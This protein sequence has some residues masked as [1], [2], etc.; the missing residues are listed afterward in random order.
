MTVKRSR[1]SS[2]VKRLELILVT[3]LASALVCALLASV[4]QEMVTRKA[5]LEGQSSAWLRAL[6]VQC[7]SALVF[8]DSAAASDILKAAGSFPGLQAILLL[9]AD[10]TVLA[11]QADIGQAPIQLEDLGSKRS[12]FDGALHISTHVFAIN[13]LVGTVHARIDLAPL[14]Q[15]LLKFALS[16]TAVLAVSG[17]VAAL[18]ARRFLRRAIMPMVDLKHAMENVTAGQNY[19]IRAVINAR[20]EVGELSGCFNAMLDQI[21]ER[22]RLLAINHANLM[23]LKDQAEQAS[24]TK[25]DFLALMSHELRTPMAGVIGMLGLALRSNMPAALRDQ[26]Q[27]TKKNAVSLLDIVNDLLDLSKIEAGKLTLER[28]DFAMAPLLDDALL[29]LHER[30]QQKSVGFVVQVDPDVPPFLLGD[31]TRLRQVLINLVGNAIKFTEKGHVRVRV[32]RVPEAGMDAKAAYQVIRFSVSD[33]GIGMSEETRARMFQKFEQADSSTTRKYGG[34]GLGLSICKQLVELMGGHIGVHSQEGKGSTFFFEVPLPLGTQP[35]D[36][37]VYEI[38]RHA[39]PLEVLVAEDSHTN[40]II[41]KALLEDMGH[42]VCIVENGRLALETLAARPFDLVLMDGRMPVMDGLEATRHIRSG[43]FGDLVFDRPQ[44][45]I[46]ALTA[47]AS[48][49]DRTNF[50]GAGMNQFLTKP[51]DEVALHRCLQHII[52]QRVAP[53]P[54]TAVKLAQSDAADPLAALDALLHEVPVESLTQTHSSAPRAPS[55]PLRTTPDLRQRVLRSFVDATPQRLADM[56]HAA[57]LGDWNTAG[58]VVH[59]IKGS[60]SYIWPDCEAYHWCASMESMADRAQ[61]EAFRTARPTLARLLIQCMDNARE[62]LRMADAPSPAPDASA[63]PTSFEAQWAELTACVARREF[64]A[65]AYARAMGHY[66][67]GTPHASTWADAVRAMDRFDYRAAHEV[68]L[69]LHAMHM[70]APP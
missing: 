27:L 43:R 6:A 25:S 4:S 23:L 69:T 35:A 3:T 61:A 54:A 52:D 67:Q 62:E 33:T 65:A 44:L 59:G 48:E 29:L 47:N 28:V 22:D 21:Q 5:E 53:R 24:R 36:A 31:P 50:L 45:P 16:L 1:Y 66:F 51:V 32:A 58:I 10:G 39:H 9:R 41:I 12:F 38:T 26:L 64:R 70:A 7:E 30:A 34:T 40:Q 37:A 20:D 13:Q 19:A 55:A 15:A 68:L 49:Q 57:A 56:D 42:Q 60:L 14:W 8:D 46:V 11:A 17:L 18:F 2:I 63:P